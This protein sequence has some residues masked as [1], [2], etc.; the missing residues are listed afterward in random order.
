M[1][2]DHSYLQLQQSKAK[3]SVFHIAAD[4]SYTLPDEGCVTRSYKLSLTTILSVLLLLCS[5]QIKRI[6]NIKRPYMTP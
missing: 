2:G 3:Q 6:L 4:H 1:N 5:M